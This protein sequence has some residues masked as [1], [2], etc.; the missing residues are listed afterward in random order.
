MTEMDDL[1]E[2]FQ[3]WQK[4]RA[5]LLAE[6]AER[7]LH[8]EIA[9][10]YKLGAAV[11]ELGIATYADVQ[12]EVIAAINRIRENE[13]QDLQHAQLVGQLMRNVQ[14]N[15]GRLTPDNHAWLAPLISYELAELDLSTQ[16]SLAS[17]VLMGVNLAAI[18]QL[19]LQLPRSLTKLYNSQDASIVVEQIMGL[20][21][22][23]VDA[24]TG[25]IPSLIEAVFAPIAK[26]ARRLTDA[27]NVLETIDK[28]VASIFAWSVTA[29]SIAIICRLIADVGARRQR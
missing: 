13:E 17:G 14:T 18:E 24:V 19:V 28:Y 1:S 23:F 4:R 22:V 5:G 7:T 8:P 20:G 10:R 21:K 16:I 25:E 27:S 9:R 3:A 29:E 6:I 11:S 15:I 12:C 26:K 2:C